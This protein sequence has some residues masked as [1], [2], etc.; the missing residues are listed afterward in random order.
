MEYP[1]WWIS[2]HQKSFRWNLQNGTFM[3][4]KTYSLSPPPI[5]P[6]LNAYKNQIKVLTFSNILP[7][8]WSQVFCLLE[9]Q[10]HSRYHKSAGNPWAS[11]LAVQG[12][13]GVSHKCWSFRQVCE[14][15]GG[16]AVEG[17]WQHQICWTCL[18]HETSGAFEMKTVSSLP[19]F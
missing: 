7:A 4:L 12:R 17:R 6:I 18:P 3:Y 2:P 11:F 13:N 14:K 19:A 5:P 15:E 16:A 10:Q 8:W 1:Q 9:S